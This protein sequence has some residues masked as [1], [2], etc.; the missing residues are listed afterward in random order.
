M[1]RTGAGPFVLDS[2]LGI[3]R[4]T[5]CESDFD[6]PYASRDHTLPRAAHENINPVADESERAYGNIGSFSHSET[7]ADGDLESNDA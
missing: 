5:S 4:R 7:D 1:A 6:T 2:C 3:I